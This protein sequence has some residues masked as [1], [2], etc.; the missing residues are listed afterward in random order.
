M[1]SLCLGQKKKKQKRK[2]E[3][4]LPQN[5]ARWEGGALWVGAQASLTGRQ[6]RRWLEE[7]WLGALGCLRGPQ[8]EAEAWP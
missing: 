7:A 5:P 4:N 6:P 2:N 8:G 3:V 1:F